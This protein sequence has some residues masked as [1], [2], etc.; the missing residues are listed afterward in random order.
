[1]LIFKNQ[2]PRPKGTGY[3]VLI[4]YLHSGFYTFFNRPRRAR[5]KGR[6]IKPLSTNKK[7]TILFILCLF[8]PISLFAEDDKIAWDNGDTQDAEI[9]PDED[10]V[11]SNNVSEKSKKVEVIVEK[12]KE[13]V[14]VPD[15]NFEIGLANFGLGFSNDFMTTFEIFREK[16]EIDID[17]LSDGFKFNVNFALIP[18]YFKYNK[19]NIWGFGLTTGLD[20][21]GIIGLNGDMLTFHEVDAAESDIGAAAFAEVKIH[22]FFTFKKIKLKIKPAMYYPIL[23]AKPNNF[24]YTFKNI[25]T[26]GI[27]ETIF[28][29]G[30]DMQVYSG[31]ST[32]GDFTIF[33]IIDHLTAK[34]GVDISLG[35]EYPLSE[36]LGLQEKHPFLNFDV[37]IDLINI[38]IYP[39]EMENYT[40]MIVN[41]GSDKPIDFFDD[42]FR[43]YEENG[44]SNFLSYNM[45]ER[46]KEKRNV[47]RPFKMLISA[48][49][50]P[51]YEPSPQDTDEWIKRKKERMVFIPTLGFAIN[52]LYYQPVSFEG[53]IG[54][55]FSLANLFIAKLGIGYYDR[56]WKNSLNLIFN[57][58]LIEFD[59]GL[60][61]QSP[62]FTKSWTGGG[63][64]VDFG[65]KLGW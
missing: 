14:R 12:E 31:F 48:D 35:A 50:R 46:G 63:Y 28:N 27:P 49:W 32:E 62:R 51:F 38:P 40:R 55:R 30:L 36:A 15:R 53:G 13:L 5:P 22:S 33:N 16:L 24:T 8:L 19:N 29:L 42:M 23:Y 1:M 37:G 43:N 11:W 58:R 61:M 7:V 20:L 60:N 47:F 3:V 65:F 17:K 57:L 56:L 52:P 54:A 41:I 59:V 26:S 21:T 9:T 4:R 64:G 25:N 34:P 10:V 6:G 2:Q 45:K 44:M 18:F 39:S